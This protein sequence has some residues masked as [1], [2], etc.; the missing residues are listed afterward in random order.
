M[1]DAT[2]TLEGFLELV[3]TVI[4]YPLFTVGSA[5]FTLAVFGKFLLVVL[6]IVALERIFRRYVLK[7]ALA[8]TK[9]DPALQFAILRITGYLFVILGIYVAFQAVGVDLSSLA[10]L[11]GA[12]GVGLGFGLQNV[13]NNFISGIIILAER[14]IAM[15]DRV[16]VAGVA[17]Q[18]TH[19]SLRST[20]ITTNDNISIIVPNSQFITETVINWSHGDPKVRMRLPVGVAYGSDTDKVRQALLEVAANHEKVLKDPAP[21]VFFNQF[22]D[23]SL[24]FELAVWTSEMTFSPRRFRSDLNFAINR[25]LREH[26]IEIPFPQRDLHIRSGTLQ[27]RQADATPPKAGS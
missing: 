15:G 21:A 12:V 16:E 3:R 11:A 6:F 9:F 27:V 17:G 13:V 4:H 5:S 1:P 14:P 25:A 19:I 2:A 24:D 18:V 20:T 7:R 8:R 26:G 23:S 22:G 10:V